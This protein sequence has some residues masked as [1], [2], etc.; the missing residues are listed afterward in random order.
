[1]HLVRLFQRVRH[2]AGVILLQVPGAAM[3]RVAQAGHQV[4]EV[5]ELIHT[6]APSYKPQATSAFLAACSLKLAA[7]LRG[8]LPLGLDDVRQLRYPAQESPERVQPRNLDGQQ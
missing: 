1:G 7:A 8:S 4:Q 5:V 6:I 2:D 3:L